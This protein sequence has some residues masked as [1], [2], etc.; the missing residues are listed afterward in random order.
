MKPEFG[1]VEQ[2]IRIRMINK[3]IESVPNG[4]DYFADLFQ[5]CYKLELF[6]LN[7]RDLKQLDRGYYNY[8]S[9]TEFYEEE[10]INYQR[11]LMKFK[12]SELFKE[13]DN[14]NQLKLILNP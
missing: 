8:I 12:P 13:K 2:I 1:N 4:M 14:P 7:F 10:Q 3:I 5:P 9:K 11:Q 6:L